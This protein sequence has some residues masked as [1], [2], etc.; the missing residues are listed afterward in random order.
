MAEEEFRKLKEKKWRRE[1]YQDKEGSKFVYWQEKGILEGISGKSEGKL[2]HVTKVPRGVIKIG[3]I[4][5]I[6]YPLYMKKLALKKYP[7]ALVGVSIAGIQ[8]LTPV[9]SQL[10]AVNPPLAYAVATSP[11]LVGVLA[12]KLRD[13]KFREEVKKDIHKIEHFITEEYEKAK[14]KIEEVI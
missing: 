1:V 2:L 12:E 14:E 13:V 6:H 4:P 3:N 5:F 10:E 11:V 7:F 8:T 9:I